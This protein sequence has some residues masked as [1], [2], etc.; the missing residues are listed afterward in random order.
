MGKF[1]PLEID[2]T[3]MTACTF[4]EPQFWLVRNACMPYWRAPRGMLTSE[5]K[6]MEEC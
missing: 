3:P 6:D 5:F 1:P 2:S 4:C